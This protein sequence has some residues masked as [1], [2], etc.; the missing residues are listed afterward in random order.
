MTDGASTWWQRMAAAV[1]DALYPPRCPLC[2]QLVFVRDRPCHECA[3]LLRPLIAEP[4][5]SHL[6]RIW[7]SRCRSRFAFEGKLREA[8]HAYK[9]GARLDL[10]RY[11]GDLLA[12]EARSLGPFDAIV[13]VPLH[14][15]RLRARGYNQS[16]LIAKRLGRTL[17]CPVWCEALERL[18]DVPPQVDLSRSERLQN[19]RGAFAVRRAD[20]VRLKGQR[21]LLIDDVLTTGATVNECARVLMRAG[22]EQVDVITIARTL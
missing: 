11:G 21:L 20:A 18:R 1:G 15:K 8:L 10:A 6:D 16:A 2:D 5:L 13:P 3:L 12:E 4:S 19:M 22:A 7:F 9:Y 17:D 14:A